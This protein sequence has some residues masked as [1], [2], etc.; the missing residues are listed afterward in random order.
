MVKNSK[1][2]E[3]FGLIEGAFETLKSE[4]AFVA[5][6]SGPARN[7]GMLGFVVG[8]EANQRISQAIGGLYLQL[9]RWDMIVSKLK[10]PATNPLQS[11]VNQIKVDFAKLQRE[12]GYI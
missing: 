7:R 6:N 4:A 2:I 3:I 1:A 8:Q 11:R 5:Y 10:L 12:I 9:L